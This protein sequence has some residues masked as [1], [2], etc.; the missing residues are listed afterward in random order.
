MYKFH[1]IDQDGNMIHLLQTQHNIIYNIIVMISAYP[2]DE[3]ILQTKVCL[4]FHFTMP[5][6]KQFRIWD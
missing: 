1:N 2:Q 5:L 4:D 3:T 6:V